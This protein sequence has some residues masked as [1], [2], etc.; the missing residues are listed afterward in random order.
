MNRR[1]RP[2]WLL[3]ISL[4]SLTGLIYLIINYS[5]NSQLSF[6]LEVPLSGTKWG[7]YSANWRISILYIFFLLFFIFLISIISYLLRSPRRAILI[8]LLTIIYLIFRMLHLS[9]PYLLFLLLALYIS[10]E[11]FFKKNI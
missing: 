2:F 8:G 6:P 9:S 5:P 3:V 7:T 11:L 4:L 10:L 1:K